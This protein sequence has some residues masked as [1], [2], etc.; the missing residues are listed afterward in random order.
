MFLKRIDETIQSGNFDLTKE[1]SKLAYL[2]EQSWE[3]NNSL[4]WKIIDKDIPVSSEILFYDDTP[5]GS[6][7]YF[8]SWQKFYAEGMGFTG[9]APYS[10]SVSIFSG[11]SP[12][13]GGISKVAVYLRYSQGFINWV[14]SFD[15]EAARA[16]EHDI[17]LFEKLFEMEGASEKTKRLPAKWHNFKLPKSLLG[18]SKAWGLP[19]LCTLSDKSRIVLFLK[20]HPS[21]NYSELEDL[22]VNIKKSL[23]LMSLLRETPHSSN[24][25]ISGEFQMGSGMGRNAFGNS[26]STNDISSSEYGRLLGETGESSREQILSLLDQKLE[27]RIKVSPNPDASCLFFL[28]EDPLKYSELQQFINKQNADRSLFF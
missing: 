19:S 6:N 8:G 2:I 16:I 10:G 27:Y 14:A 26:Y 20:E 25:I 15:P 5:D 23:E 17:P 22:G 12:N 13:F 4:Q 18:S 1:D 11:A 7:T 21:G 28:P 3:E 9:N 24:E